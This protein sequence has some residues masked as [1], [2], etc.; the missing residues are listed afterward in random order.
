MKYRFMEHSGQYIEGNRK[1]EQ[2]KNK[3]DRKQ[4]STNHTYL[5]S[6]IFFI[7]YLQNASAFQLIL[8]EVHPFESFVRLLL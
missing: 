1:Y 5:F 7:L 6:N 2:R 4:K 3:Q 8:I